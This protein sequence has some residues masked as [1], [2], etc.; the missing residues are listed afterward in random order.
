VAASVRARFQPCL[1]SDCPSPLPLVPPNGRGEGAAKQSVRSGKARLKACPDGANQ[2]YG[3]GQLRV[4]GGK[5]A[6]DNRLNKPT[7][8]FWRVWWRSLSVKRP[9]ALVA[10]AAL[11]VGAALAAMLL[12]LYSSVHRKMTEEFQ[13]YGANVIVSPPP[14]AN[15]GAA[16]FDLAEL[17]RVAQVSEKGKPLSAVP[18][19]YVAARLRRIPADPR[20]PEFENAV[21]VG[22]DFAALEALNPGWRVTGR[23]PRPEE[24]ALSKAKGLGQPSEE[25]EV[26]IGAR[27]AERLKLA[28]SDTISIG[29]TSGG[30]AS[31]SAARFRVGAVVSTGAAEDDQV[32]VPLNRLQTLA[33][34]SGKISL[35]EL[36][37]AGETAQV[38]GV[39]RELAPNLP[40]LDVRPV[41]QIVYSAG[42]VLDTIRW[43]LVSLS[44]LILV[45]LALAVAA[46]MTAIALERRKDIAVMK[47]LGAGD[48]L[49]MRL[50]LAEGA[51]IGLAGGAVGFLLGTELAREASRRIFDVALKLDWKTLPIVLAAS[52]ILAAAA[53]LVPARLISAVQ[54][55][56]VLKGE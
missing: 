19:L 50:F 28:S 13:A 29:P 32:F 52:V 21:A 48:Q 55:A 22:A 30:P 49:V 40:G 12:T 16:T 23:L 54:P 31:T 11:G 35:I 25:A 37:V 15:G 34:L 39:V 10:V 1:G 43:L 36:S 20:L 24:P 3:A 46:T 26:V 38:E 47:A 18:V 44:A 45:I 42:H 56:A 2:G 8:L 51:A 14:D 33:G 7:R 27:V 6:V 9:Q 41:R 4:S 17:E 53:T 5:D